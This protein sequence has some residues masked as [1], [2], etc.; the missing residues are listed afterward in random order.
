MGTTAIDDPGVCQSVT[1]ADC[2]KTAENIDV[3]FGV[4][5]PEAS[6]NIALYRGPYPHGEGEGVRCGL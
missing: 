6:R 4:K 2:A 5:T 1:R 3:L